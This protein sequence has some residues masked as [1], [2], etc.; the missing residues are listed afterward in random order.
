MLLL[1]ACGARSAEGTSA[2]WLE[3]VWSDG[4]TTEAWASDGSV[5]YGASVNGDA[6]ELMRF[7]GRHLLAAPSGTS[8]VRFATRRTRGGS[9]EVFLEGHDPE[10]VRYAREGDVLVA[11]IGAEAEHA[12]W[13]LLPLEGWEP[14]LAPVGAKV[15]RREDGVWLTLEPC[16]C[17][18]RLRCVGLHEDGVL[19][20]FAGVADGSCDAC[21][22]V[23]ARCEVD[24]GEATTV[25]LGGRALSTSSEGGFE[26]TGLVLGLPMH[27]GL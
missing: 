5:L 1:V 25:T 3:G 24:E 2:S 20:L 19:T 6:I 16:H 9:F 17:G 14:L 8:P 21:L 7:D 26:G 13:R 18:A 15:E 10:W 23:S 22:P 12:R 4:E 11:S 27:T